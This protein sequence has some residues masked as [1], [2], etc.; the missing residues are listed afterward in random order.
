VS[1]R[2]FDGLA[3]G[4]CEAAIGT[5]LATSDLEVLTMLPDGT[6]SVD[7][8]AGNCSHSSGVPMSLSLVS[9]LRDWFES[10][11]RPRHIDRTRVTG[12]LVNIAY[13]TGAIETD[14]DT[15]VHFILGCQSHVQVG[16]KVYARSITNKRVWHR[17]NG[18]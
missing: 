4:L 12:A 11:F 14:R 17:R 9:E 15:L 3:H 10:Q 16:D 1:K 13:D 2:S 8:I 7:V 5:R 6:V 18:A